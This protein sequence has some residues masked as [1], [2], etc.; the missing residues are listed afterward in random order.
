M[1]RGKGD[2]EPFV[3]L[4]Q[5]SNSSVD[6][7]VD[8]VK[9]QSRVWSGNKMSGGPGTHHTYVALNCEIES[10]LVTV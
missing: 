4:L 1:E 10:R 9:A 6:T 3:L 8:K 2:S 5:D 7:V